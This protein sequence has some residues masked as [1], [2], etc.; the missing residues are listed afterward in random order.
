MKNKLKRCSCGV[1]VYGEQGVK[2]HIAEKHNHLVKMESM[3]PS[4]DWRLILPGLDH[5][6]MNGCKA[7]IDFL[8]EPFFKNICIR[9]GYE[10][11]HALEVAKKCA[12]LHQSDQILAVFL[13]SGSQILAKE[14][15]KEAGV[16][17]LS[18]LQNYSPIVV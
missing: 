3:T 16:D 7:I 13:E 15:Y 8:W 2:K 12:D 11:P 14:Y 4:L 5:L 10:T 6:R 9:L 1:D 17:I 18:M